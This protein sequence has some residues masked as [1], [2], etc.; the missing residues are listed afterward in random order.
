MP[1]DGTEISEMLKLAFGGDP[2]AVERLLP[3][4]Y[5]RLRRLAESMMKK[6]R[7]GQTIQAT[8]LVHEAY[9][10][11][12]GSD[13]KSWNDQRHFFNTAALAMRRCLVDRARARNGP[14]R[15]P[16]GQRA[17]LDGVEVPAEEYFRF[18]QLE[19]VN[20]LVDQLRDHNQRWSEVVHLRLYLGMPVQLVAE[21]LEVSPA[22]IKNDWRFALA[23][24]RL[25]LKEGE[26]C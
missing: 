2:D 23:W 17:A 8:A 16:G 9:L 25:K 22:T 10:R 6:E 4:V 18:E 26:N 1:E 24:L 20:R 15:N 3:M 13:Q 19:S 12:M 21:M 11:L 14:Q 7:P 5:D